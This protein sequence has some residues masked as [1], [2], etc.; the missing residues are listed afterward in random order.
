MAVPIEP[1]PITISANT[2]FPT[3]GPEK[4]FDTV[5]FIEKEGFGPLWER[6]RLAERF[7]LAVMSTKGMSVTAARLLL[8]RLC[9]RGLKR[10]LV[11]HDF[12]VSGFSIFGTLGTSG[13]RYQFKNE[14]PLIDLGL[15]L[16]NVTAMSLQ[17]E[18]VDVTG[19]W[20][21]RAA[22]LRQ[23]GATAD[24]IEFL[25]ER[26]VELNAMTSRQLV[27]FIEAQLALHGVAK[28]IPSDDFLEKHA[29]HL[30]EQRLARDAFEQLR[31]GFAE[32]AKAAELPADLHARLEA[33]LGRHPQ[34]SWDVALAAVIA[35]KA[36]ED[37]DC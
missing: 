10:I 19:D 25:R 24:E 31:A 6:V 33:I 11:L 9:D 5:L 32:Q 20:E 23:H 26:R 2:R 14:V 22:T 8:D 4:R 36:L 7:D 30:I 18:P 27:E 3:L 35:D 17:S 15:R 21:K 37:A 34:L 13:R 16:V 28:L 12:D 29:R 1:A